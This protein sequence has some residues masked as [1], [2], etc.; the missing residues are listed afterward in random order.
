MI[1]PTG[2]ERDWSNKSDEARQSDERKDIMQN[3]KDNAKRRNH[4]KSGKNHHSADI[5]KKDVQDLMTKH[6]M[7]EA[8]ALEVF[9]GVTP[10]EMW[11]MAHGQSRKEL[12]ELQLKKAKDFSPQ[13]RFAP[14]TALAILN[15]LFKL[16]EYQEQKLTKMTQEKQAYDLSQKENLSLST[17]LSIVSG[18]MTLEEYQAKEQSKQERREKAIE[19]HHKYPEIPLNVCYQIVDENVT[20]QQYQERKSLRKQRRQTWYLNYVKQNQEKNVLLAC[21]LQKLQHKKIKTYIAL[22]NQDSIMGIVVGYTPYNVKMKDRA[23]NLTT[24]TKLDIKYLC[25]GSYVEPIFSKMAIDRERQKTRSLPD[26]DPQQ[27]YL[28][29]EELLQE[30]KMIELVLVSGET[31]KGQINWASCYEI[32]LL[33]A[34]RPKA[35]AVIFRHAVIEAKEIHL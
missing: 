13:V 35:S 9:H 4:K 25:R 29:P 14:K 23:G 2:R 11:Q 1:L 26:A 27:R 28:I 6:N 10:L 24:L 18:Q 19:T 5:I 7:N 3:Y 15:A 34:E 31:F 21:Y 16:P 33:L 22:F 17:A 32:K 20:V 8:V 12:P 30:G